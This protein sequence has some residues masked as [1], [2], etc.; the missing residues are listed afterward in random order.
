MKTGIWLSDEDISKINEKINKVY[1]LYPEQFPNILNIIIKDLFDHEF[2]KDKCFNQETQDQITHT[3]LNIA[4]KREEELLDLVRVLWTSMNPNDLDRDLTDQELKL[5]NL[6][7][8][9]MWTKVKSNIEVDR[10]EIRRNKQFILNCIP[11]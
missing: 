5:I 3:L 8:D 4:S 2:D 1:Q 10:D 9:K 7:M 6:S 11:D